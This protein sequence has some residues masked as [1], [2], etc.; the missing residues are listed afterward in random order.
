MNN[1]QK[2]KLEIEKEENSIGVDILLKYSSVS[3][4]DITEDVSLQ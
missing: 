4:I 1:K 2:R 3:Y